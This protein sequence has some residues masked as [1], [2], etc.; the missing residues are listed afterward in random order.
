[1]DELSRR[2]AKV[3]AAIHKA[4]KGTL[5]PVVIEL[6]APADVISRYRCP[7]GV[8]ERGGVQPGLNTRASY[9]KI[10]TTM[11]VSPCHPRT[12]WTKNLGRL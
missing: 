6:R 3:A 7:R 11:V 1:M 8:G 2:L 5:D 9:G 12:L 10:H 4:N